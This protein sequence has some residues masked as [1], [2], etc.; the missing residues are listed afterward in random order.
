MKLH[1]ETTRV[2]EY[3]RTHR[4]V[5]IAVLTAVAIALHVLEA[6]LPA[7]TFIPGAK[8]GLANITTLLALYC[9]GAVRGIQVAALRVVM[10]S[11]LTGTLLTTAFFL[12]GAGAVCSAIIMGLAYTYMKTWLSIRS[13]SLLGAI[14]HNLAQLMMASIIISDIRIFVY[15]PWLLILSVP[16][17]WVT[18]M[19]AQR[20]CRIFKFDNEMIG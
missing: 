1:G 18:G 13:I 14:T 15:L 3:G 5:Q 2:F 4:L 17:G 16:T 20:L 12:S 7:P 19:A 9:F 10:G 11:L 6:V 8:L